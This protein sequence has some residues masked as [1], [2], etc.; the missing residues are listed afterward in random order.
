MFLD[1]YTIKDSPDLLFIAEYADL[2][3][4]GMTEEEALSKLV[5]RDFEQLLIDSGNLE[6]AGNYQNKISGLPV[7]D[8]NR[9]TIQSK[10]N[11][12]YESR[13]NTDERNRQLYEQY[14]ALGTNSQAKLDLI[15]PIGTSISQTGPADVTLSI[16]Q[17]GNLPDAL[18]GSTSYDQEMNL[19]SHISTTRLIPTVQ[20]STTIAQR[21]PRS[22]N[23]N[24]SS[25]DRIYQNV[26]SLSHQ[27]VGLNGKSDD[28]GSMGAAHQFIEGGI[29]S[30]LI[31]TIIIHD[32]IVGADPNK[33]SA[34]KNDQKIQVARGGIYYLLL[35]DNGNVLLDPSEFDTL[36]A[37]YF[38]LENNRYPVEVQ[39]QVA[40]Y[41]KQLSIDHAQYPKH[42]E[43]LRK[44]VEYISRE[45]KNG[46]QVDLNLATL[47]NFLTNNDL[48]T[49]DLT[50]YQTVD[51]PTLYS[52]INKNTTS[53]LRWKARAMLFNEYND[54]LG[55][56]ITKSLPYQ[57]ISLLTRKPNAFL[58]ALTQSQLPFIYDTADTLATAQQ[59]TQSLFT[60]LL[61]PVD[62][63]TSIHNDVRQLA[64]YLSDTQASFMRKLW[65]NTWDQIMQNSSPDEKNKLEYYRQIIAPLITGSGGRGEISLGSDLDYALLVDD[66][67]LDIP[68]DITKEVFLKELSYFVNNRLALTMNQQLISH[69][70]R[71]DAGLGKADRQPFS[72]ISDIQNLQLFVGADRQTENPTEIVAYTPLYSIHAPLVEKAKYT[73]YEN[74]SVKKD[75][76]NFI[77][78]ALIDTDTNFV[79]YYENMYQNLAKGQTVEKLK[80]SMQRVLNFKL[81]QLL[82][83]A[84]QYNWLSPEELSLAP[85]NTW[86]LIDYLESKSLL[87]S[88]EANTSRNLLS[89]AY[90]LRILSEIYSSE[91]QQ[92]TGLSKIKNITFRLE[93]LS[94]SEREQLFSTIKSFHDRVL[95]KL[96]DPDDSPN[97][98]STQSK[99]TPTSPLLAFLPAMPSLTGL[100]AQ[101]GSSLLSALSPY[102]APFIPNLP[103]LTRNIQIWVENLNIIPHWFNN[104]FDLNLDLGNFSNIDSNTLQPIRTSNQDILKTELL[105]YLKVPNYG[106]D[107]DSYYG[108]GKSAAEALQLFKEYTQSLA[109]LPKYSHQNGDEDFNLLVKLFEVVKRDP[110]ISTKLITFKPNEYTPTDPRF[111]LLPELMRTNMA[112]YT[113]EVTLDPTIIDLWNTVDNYYAK[114]LEILQNGDPSTLEHIAYEQEIIADRLKFPA[115]RYASLNN[116]LYERSV[117]DQLVA[118]GTVLG[119]GTYVANFKQMLVDGYFKSPWYAMQTDDPALGLRSIEIDPGA[120]F[121]YS[122]QNRKRD[123]G[124]YTEK[125]RGVSDI[126]ILYPVDTLMQSGYTIGSKNGTNSESE[127]FVTNSPEAFS[128]NDLSPNERREL[129]I[130]DTAKL[131]L[132]YAYL[133][134]NENVYTETIA[135]L[136]TNGFDDAWIAEHVY[137]YGSSNFSTG[138][139]YNN[140]LSTRNYPKLDPKETPTYTPKQ[141]WANNYFIWEPE[142]TIEQNKEK[143]IT[144]NPESENAW[145]NIVQV[146]QSNF[147]LRHVSSFTQAKN[148]AENGFTGDS[149][150]I[151][152]IEQIAHRL[153]PDKFPAQLLGLGLFKSID[154][155]NIEKESILLSYEESI[156]DFISSSIGMDINLLAS[157]NATIQDTINHLQQATTFLLIDYPSKLSPSEQNKYFGIGKIGRRPISS[158]QVK[159][160]ASP[161][162]IS[163]DKLYLSPEE[164]NKPLSSES[165][166]RLQSS[167]T[168]IFFQEIMLKIYP[169]AYSSK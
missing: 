83:Q 118:P 14:I 40:A 61:F 32:S 99:Q 112:V 88:V 77:E 8:P 97:T 147:G 34:D 162:I 116:Y 75:L 100:G 143:P 92:S 130:Q 144:T 106:N 139:F 76:T 110:T 52:E 3:K 55:N 113:N 153:F 169:L 119:H 66:T 134:I 122:N 158:D 102:I 81:W 2:V 123:V 73:L 105:N 54:A 80:E 50:W 164:L 1:K 67:A 41:Y 128:A 93:D 29:P 21:L 74:I 82:S 115:D 138:K 65:E 78:N 94:Y 17:T 33:F 96:Y 63:N 109:T 111:S 117:K 95:Y 72:T 35:D 60:K 37:L 70:I 137:K 145:N 6:L 22:G 45:L 24:G 20:S 168:N 69:G 62:N 51:F 38:P 39:D 47:T 124:S 98:I 15:I 12:I 42:W 160:I 135:L 133:R 167:L 9:M 23:P 125:T 149:L 129:A 163:T 49:H 141:G 25:I 121:F 165:F 53:K 87:T 136:K 58:D 31:S 48:N 86:D 4:I 155:S 13:K 64:S 44:A 10:I 84:Y 166:N 7:G 19:S 150:A 85:S 148:E 131:D 30:S 43:V 157:D 114:I 89:N 103:L 26:S 59:T 57:E 11:A 16:I 101:S 56:V 132:H 107:Y 152:S 146:E 154:F 159:L 91:A 108:S 36:R 120:I 156:K 161:T 126:G 68:T 127:Y 140:W 71:A 151:S 104:L 28:G 79:T 90:K 5:S 142:N 27:P 18:L 46:Q